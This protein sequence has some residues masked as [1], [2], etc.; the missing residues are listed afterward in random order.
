MALGS[1]AAAIHTRVCASPVIGSD[2]TGMRIDC[3]DHIFAPAMA[4]VF[5]AALRLRA[6]RPGMDPVLFARLHQRI[7]SLCDRL[8]VTDTPHRDGV[9]LQWRYRDHR[10]KLFVFLERP[11]V[12][13]DN[14]A[15]ERALRTTVVHPKVTGCF[16]S[17]GGAE[18]YSTILSVIETA[19]KS[20]HRLLDTLR[21]AIEPVTPTPL[22][23]FALA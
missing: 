11:D 7:E 13:P 16:R 4:E 14:N 21:I 8:L 12:P 23:R 5:R 18:T 6:A 10:A 1:A 22:P 15:S 3:G 2:E 20:G 17:D 19:K 9:R